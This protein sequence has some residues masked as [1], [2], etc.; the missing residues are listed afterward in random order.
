V[1]ARTV[2]V[3]AGAVCAIGWFSKM[4]VM[5]AQGGPEA[6]SIPETLAFLVGLVSFVVFAAALGHMLMRAHRPVMKALA[7]VAAVVLAALTLGVVQLLLTAL[8]DDAW[9][10]PE[11][12]FVGAGVAALLL[13]SLLGRRHDAAAN[14]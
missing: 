2:T 3:A 1:N 6:G 12:A 13:P 5:V 9:W 11:L 7:S 10:Q 14:G 4:A 8:P